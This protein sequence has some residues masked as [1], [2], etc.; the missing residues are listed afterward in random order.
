MEPLPPALPP[1]NPRP[2]RANTRARQS[3]RGGN[4][5]HESN[6]SRDGKGASNQPM[7]AEDLALSPRKVLL[8]DGQEMDRAQ[9]GERC[10]SAN[11]RVDSSAI[12]AQ[13]RFRKARPSS[14]APP[15][16]TS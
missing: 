2:R 16:Y 6:A 14:A 1:A 13:R 3:S 9:H 11:P 8:N 7:T 4:K 10:E 15:T 5:D 12:P